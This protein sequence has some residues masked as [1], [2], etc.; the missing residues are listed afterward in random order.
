MS[1]AIVGLG[2]S[3]AITPPPMAIAADA[4]AICVLKIAA[5]ANI[6]GILANKPKAFDMTVLVPK[7]SDV[8]VPILCATLKTLSLAVTNQGTT[9][10]SFSSQVFTNQ[11]VPICGKGPYKVPVNGSRGLMYAN[12]MGK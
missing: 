11:G 8:N 3:W 9:D 12:C 4:G 6:V 5:D 2:V 10:I 1:L 7:D